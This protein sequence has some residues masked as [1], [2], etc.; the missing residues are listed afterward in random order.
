MVLITGGFGYLG[1]RIAAYLR[2][3]GH[4]VR[5]GTSREKIGPNES[6]SSYEVVT[7]NLLDKKSLEAACKSVSIVIHLAALNAQ[8]CEK[9][10]EKASKINIEGTSKLINAAIKENVVK[11]IYFSTAHVYGSPLSGDLNENILPTPQHPYAITHYIAE[12]HLVKASN[13]KL[14]E[15]VVLRL[16][17]AVGAP[18]HKNVNCWMLVSNDLCRQAVTKKI[19]TLKSYS[20]L[21]R[22]FISIL[23]ICKVVRNIINN[24]ELQNGVFNLSSGVS[25]T[26]RDLANLISQR[27]TKILKYTPSVEFASKDDTIPIHYESLHI[28]NDKL[29][30]Y[31]VKV[32]SNIENEIDDL[33]I[34]CN[35]WFFK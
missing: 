7:I 26:L 21:E 33:L 22:D 14:I 30:K 23:D 20:L 11:F 3:S 5:I 16:T 27:A 4:S 2:Q 8:S 31:G 6:H 32:N 9:D 19:M 15:G 34:N 24:L 35:N 17:N 10:P 12:K 1:G 18:L 28:S 13:N 25:L 29:K